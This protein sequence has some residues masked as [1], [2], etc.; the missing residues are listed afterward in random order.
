MSSTKW[1]PGGHGFP[2]AWGHLLP[3]CLGGLRGRGW[4]Q[5][6]RSVV[7]WIASE[8]RMARG[9]VAGSPTDISLRIAQRISCTLHRENARAI[10]RRSPDSVNGSSGLAGNLV[11][12]SLSFFLLF[13]GFRVFL[14][15]PWCV[16]PSV[17]ARV[18]LIALFVITF[19]A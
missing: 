11:S 8:S 15:A 9:P 7:A 14:F 2:G 5:A 19:R 18:V 3:A 17:P 10:L 12:L 4:S 13:F 16:A 1:S 6:L